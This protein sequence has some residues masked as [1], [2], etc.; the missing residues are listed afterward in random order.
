MM[1]LVRMQHKIAF[2]FNGIKLLSNETIF[3]ISQF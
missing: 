1:T 3:E 2:F